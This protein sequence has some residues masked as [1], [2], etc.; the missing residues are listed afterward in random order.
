MDFLALLLCPCHRQWL[1]AFLFYRSLFARPFAHRLSPG[2]LWLQSLSLSKP[3][4][5]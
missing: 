4:A 5:V 1:R 2:F 3:R